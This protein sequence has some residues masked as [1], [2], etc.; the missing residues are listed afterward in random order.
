MTRL[1]IFTIT[2]VF[3]L[4][5]CTSFK[6]LS[7]SNSKPV[8][9]PNQSKNKEVKFLDNVSVS[10]QSAITKINPN[11]KSTDITEEAN[12]KSRSSEL[13]AD[14][15]SGIENASS[16]QIRYSILLNTEV[17]EV[18][19]FKMYAYIDDWYGTRYCM[20]G[21][22]KSCI[23]CSAFVQG[24][25]AAIYGITLPRTAREQYKKAKKISRTVMDEGD[26]LFFNTAG[27]VSHV[28]IYLQ[29]NK[30]VHSS[31]SGGVMISDVFDP[32]WVRRFIGAGRIEKAMATL[33]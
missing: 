23:D 6:P 7:I 17:E 27:G 13:F 24:V 29:N 19:N 9:V 11:K 14:Q 26:L 31:A 22:T 2:I 18:Q 30:F 15:N 1:F 4:A 20:G 8:Q 12:R 10:P 3:V 28:G 32:Y 21:T 16:L 5:G 33:P 25:F